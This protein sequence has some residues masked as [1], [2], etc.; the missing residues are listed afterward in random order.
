M[1]WLAIYEKQALEDLLV[2]V[3]PLRKELLELDTISKSS[4]T[5]DESSNLQAVVRSITSRFIALKFVI[6]R[7]KIAA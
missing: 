7:K 6:G 1:D 5:A 3:S 4:L 2:I